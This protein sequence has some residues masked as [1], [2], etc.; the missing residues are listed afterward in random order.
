M[1]KGIAQLRP[2]YSQH[3]SASPEVEKQGRFR[4]ITSSKGERGTSA[5][6]KTKKPEEERVARWGQNYNL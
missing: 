5:G 3:P 6:P 4:G 2:L 1:L